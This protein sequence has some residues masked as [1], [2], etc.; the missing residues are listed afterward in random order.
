MTCIL[1]TPKT[2]R[3]E[4]NSTGRMVEKTMY[5]VVIPS[6]KILLLRCDNTIRCERFKNFHWRDDEVEYELS[7]GIHQ[8][9]K[10]KKFLVLQEILLLLAQNMT[11]ESQLAVGTSLI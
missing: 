1:L 6:E 7:L 5:R 11:A 4:I 10:I 2:V 9:E 8:I 3:A